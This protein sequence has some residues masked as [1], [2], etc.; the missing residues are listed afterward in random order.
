MDV[1]KWYYR[2]TLNEFG[3]IKGRIHQYLDVSGKLPASLKKKVDLRY[4]MFKSIHKKYRIIMVL[5]IISLILMYLSVSSFVLKNIPV[6]GVVKETAAI[7]TGLVGLPIFTILY[8]FFS[9][10][11]R[12]M[13]VDAHFLMAEIISLVTSYKR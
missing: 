1:R 9:K 5:K 6:V 7:I 4:D 13:L 12:V 10:I 8:L 11:G 3:K 2:L